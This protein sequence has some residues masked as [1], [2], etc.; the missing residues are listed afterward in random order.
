MTPNLYNHGHRRRSAETREAIA[1]G[2]EKLAAVHAIRAALL[3]T[4][5][6]EEGEAVL[7]EIVALFGPLTL[8]EI[9]IL[10]GLCRERVRQIEARAME[11]LRR[12]RLAALLPERNEVSPFEE[13]S[14]YHAEA[15]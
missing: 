5:R 1:R 11:K 14:L 10:Y 4:T 6:S 8:E 9:G 7:C 2:L 15:A 13:L 3:E 12:P